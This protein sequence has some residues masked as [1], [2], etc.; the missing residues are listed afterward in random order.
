M[1]PKI[2]V[3]K[4][5]WKN[6]EFKGDLNKA[7][8]LVSQQVIAASKGCDGLAWQKFEAPRQSCVLG[9]EQERVY[10]FQEVVRRTGNEA[11]DKRLN[12]EAAF[13]L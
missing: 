11:C 3:M 9:G 2:D 6:L 1:H 7:R 13:L 4:K 8:L 10:T 12:D 5:K